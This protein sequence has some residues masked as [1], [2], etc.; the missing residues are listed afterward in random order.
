M[1][2]TFAKYAGIIQTLVGVAGKFAPDSIKNLLMSAKDAAAAGGGIGGS[3]IVSIVIGLVLSYFGFKGSD[4][5]QRMGAQVGGGLSA[6][7]GVLGVANVGADL[8][9]SQG[10][11]GANVVN[12]LIGAWGL[13][14]GFAKKTAGAAA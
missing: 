3:S 6:L 11:S 4:S 13:Y 9:L 2:Q 7:V 12:M 14:S 8:G 5:Q 10:L 1:A